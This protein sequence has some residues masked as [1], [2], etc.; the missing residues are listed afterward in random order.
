MKKERDYFWWI[1]VGF[2]IAVPVLIRLFV[3]GTLAV[4]HYL[5]Y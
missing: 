4:G 2:M 5:G 1:I 3:V